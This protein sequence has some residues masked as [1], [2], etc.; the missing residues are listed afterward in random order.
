[1]KKM[2]K[3][4]ATSVATMVVSTV[5]M[6]GMFVNGGFESG[7]FSSWTNGQ[8]TVSQNG[9]IRE[10]TPAAGSRSRIVTDGVTYSG[11]SDKITLGTDNNS[12]GNLATVFNGTYA[13]RVNDLVNSSHYSFISQTVTGYTDPTI[14]F[15]WAAVLLKPSGT[16]H[17]DLE[18]PYFYVKLDDL[19][20]ATTLYDVSFDSTWSPPPYAFH[21]GIASVSPNSP[22]TWQYTDWNPVAMD[23]SALSGH[24]F[25]LTVM[26]A[27]CTLGG[28]GGYAYVDAFDSVLLDANPGVTANPLFSLEAVPE[29]ATLSLMALGL[30]AFGYRRFYGRA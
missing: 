30:L 21:D 4:V 16:P 29:P 1:M 14:Y 9:T 10:F 3:K 13:A 20:T 24:D 2:M 11:S 19:T 8:G 15:A 27:D 18:T 25:Q 22:G 12:G 7:D 26:A 28:H 23:V 17:N 6:A 5:A